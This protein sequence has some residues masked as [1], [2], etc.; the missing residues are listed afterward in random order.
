MRRLMIRVA[1]MVAAPGL[2]GSVTAAG[3]SAA[4]GD[5]FVLVTAANSPFGKRMAGSTLTSDANG[6]LVSAELNYGRG[7]YGMLRARADVAA[8]WERFHLEVW[9]KLTWTIRSGANQKFVSAELN[10]DWKNYAMLRARA[11]VA[12]EWEKFDL[13]YNQTR[14]LWAFKSK[15][16]GKFVSAELNYDGDRNGMLRARADYIGPWEWFRMG[17]A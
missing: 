16:N 11:D 4:T 14:D 5:R 1:L 3:A 10:Y 12:G 7:D 2:L 9:G 8:E 17:G 6:K 15:A 13:Y